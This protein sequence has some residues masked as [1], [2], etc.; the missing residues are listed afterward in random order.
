MA[1]VLIAA[2]QHVRGSV[3]ATRPV[4][5]RERVTEQ[6]TNPCVLRNCGEPLVEQVLQ[7][8]VVRSD[9]E[10]TCPEVGAPMSNGLNEAYELLLK[11]GKLGMLRRHGAAEE[12]DRPLAL[13]EDR[14]KTRS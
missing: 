14:P 3:L 6:L 2:R 11:S 4:N 12:G 7:A 13:M 10:R 8:A 5:H 9:G 1:R